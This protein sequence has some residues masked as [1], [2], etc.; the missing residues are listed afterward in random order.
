MNDLSTLVSE[1]LVEALAGR[2]A[3]VNSLR[4]L[5]GMHWMSAGE[6]PGRVRHTIFRSLLHM[7][8]WQDVTLA[9][10]RGEARPDP[11]RPEQQWPGR[12]EPGNRGEWD[13]A[14]ERF[15][16]G[17]EGL[18]EAARAGDLARVVHPE[19]GE[20]ALAALL[21]VAQHNAY[22]MGQIV[23]LR[24][25]LGAWPPPEPVDTW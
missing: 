7:N 18:Q 20:T 5:A 23:L 19:K 22:H 4:A 15:R 24:R 8:Y 1:Q 11:V 16:A 14:V 10:L 17:M 13:A 12:E 6:R 9:R 2:G 25:Q 21:G 3:Y